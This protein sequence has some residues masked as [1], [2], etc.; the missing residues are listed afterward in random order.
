MRALLI[1]FGVTNQAVAEALQKRGHEF[2]VVDDKDFGGAPDVAT[3]ERIIDEVDVVIPSP[4]VGDVHVALDL[5]RRA[6][7]PVRSEFDLAVEWDSRPLLAITGTDGKTT[8]TTLSTNMLQASGVRAAAVGNTEVPLV[9]AIEDPAVDVFVVEASSFRIDHSERFAPSVGTWLNFS[10]DHLNL[11]RSLESYELAKA[12]LWRDQSP[13]DVAIGFDDDPVVMRHLRAAPARHVTFGLGAGADYRVDNDRLVTDT[14]DVLADL[15]ELPRRFP[16]DL[17]NGLA[18][19]AT[20][21]AGGATIEGCHDALVRFDGLPHR[22]ALIGELDG[23]RWYDDSKA[24]TPNATL[25]ATKAFDSIVLIAGGQN[26]GLDLG[27]LAG[28]APRIRAVVAIGDAAGEV[29]SAFAGVRPVVVA[30]SMTTAVAAARELAQPGDTVLL[31]PA[32]ASFDW[33]GSYGERGDD[34]T[35]QVRTLLGAST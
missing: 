30:E 20:A 1:G 13:T 15:A 4:G 31:S 23:V 34:F 12:K 32:C 8:V 14:G 22:I 11:H 27:V 33:Y 24:T 5:A 28:A 19:A 21:L 29:E 10:P 6:G 17:T 3:Y 26:K 25:T 9:A 18:A 2:V 7:V 16:H 35:T